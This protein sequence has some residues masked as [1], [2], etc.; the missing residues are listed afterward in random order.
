MAH[1][2]ALLL[3]ASQIRTDYEGK[4]SKS[5]LMSS[6]GYNTVLT[7]D[8]SLP[9]VPVKVKGLTPHDDWMKLLHAQN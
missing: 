7:Q 6:F 5:T 9:Q 3:F 2:K 4:I 8:A 1:L